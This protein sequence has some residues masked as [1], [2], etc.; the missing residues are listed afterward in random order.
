MKTPTLASM[1]LQPNNPARAGEKASTYRIFGNFS[2][3]AVYA[4]H[5]RFETVQWFVV[6][7]E[8]PVDPLTGDLAVIRQN[9]D[10]N[11]AVAG[12]E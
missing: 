3:Y 2:R 12:L 9:D 7:A 4:V 11:Q 5:T 1:N 6:D 10:F 8:A